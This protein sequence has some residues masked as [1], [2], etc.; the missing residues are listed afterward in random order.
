MINKKVFRHSGGTCNML[1]GG[2]NLDEMILC[3]SAN[4]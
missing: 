2:C 1:L 4:S 3:F